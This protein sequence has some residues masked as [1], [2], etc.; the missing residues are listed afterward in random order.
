[1]APKN[2]DRKLLLLLPL[3][4]FLLVAFAYLFSRHFD[5]ADRSKMPAGAQNK[6]E[7][8]YEPRVYR[9]PAEIAT[10]TD[11]LLISKNLPTSTVNIPILLYHYLEPIDTKDRLRAGMTVT[12]EKFAEQLDLIKRSGVETLTISQVAA[13][14]GGSAAKG[15]KIALTFDD[16]YRDFYQYAFPLLKKYQIKATVYVIYNAINDPAYLSEEMIKEMLSSGLVEIGSHD[17]DHKKL[18]SLSAAEARRQIFLSKKMFEER[19]KIPIH[20]LAYPY[21]SFNRPI[22]D[23]VRAA[24][25][26]AAVSVITGE[27]QSAANRYFLFRL[28]SSNSG[29]ALIKHLISDK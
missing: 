19:F 9:L 14:L 20:T 5:A 6:T 21:G 27:K 3:S 8:Y 7:I 4:L 13:L 10:S 12:P 28:R 25:Y 24:G 18:T 26:R 15:K 1:M 29:D 22:A 2:F 16:G 11:A 23:L 17:L